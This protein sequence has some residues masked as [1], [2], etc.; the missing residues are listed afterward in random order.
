MQE[1]VKQVETRQ[2]NREMSV[3]QQVGTGN[4]FAQGSASGQDVKRFKDA[5]NRA[6]DRLILQRLK[7]V[8]G[9]AEDSALDGNGPLQGVKNV[10]PA[11]FYDHN[12][13]LMDEDVGDLCQISE[14]GRVNKGCKPISEEEDLKIG[15]PTDTG[16]VFAEANTTQVN[17]IIPTFSGREVR[18]LAQKIVNE[19]IIH[20]AILNERQEVTVILKDCRLAGAHVSLSNE[21]GTLRV[22][23]SSLTPEMAT[24]VKLNQAALCELLAEKVNVKEVKITT[25]Q[26]LRE[27]GDTNHGRSKGGFGNGRNDD[28]DEEEMD[29]QGRR[30]R[31]TGRVGRKS[32][33]GHA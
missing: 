21:G 26:Q 6:D 29:S 28:D 20:E 17:P 32:A 16:V 2:T 25:S 4:S 11:A 24:V 1:H 22:S 19:L 27:E 10:A 18:Q 7:V 23:F 8:F 3:E 13:E 14:T 30:L 33:L 15:T 9:G 12:S 31:R 5:Y